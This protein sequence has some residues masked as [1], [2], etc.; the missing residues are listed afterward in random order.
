MSKIISCACGSRIALR[1]GACPRCIDE[2]WAGLLIEVMRM[3]LDRWL[4]GEGL[5]T[6][7]FSSSGT[8]VLLRASVPPAA[9]FSPDL[10]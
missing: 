1:R 4:A 8:R 7:A 3:V 9:G 2:A 6:A 10:T 5:L